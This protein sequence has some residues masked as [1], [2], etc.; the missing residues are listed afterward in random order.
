MV[1]NN[2][3]L[4]KVEST[5]FMQFKQSRAVPKVTSAIRYSRVNIRI[6][7]EFRQKPLKALR[8][9]KYPIA[10]HDVK[11]SP[12]TDPSEATFRHY[13]RLA[14]CFTIFPYLVK[15]LVG[16]NQHNRLDRHLACKLILAI[17]TGKVG[18]LLAPPLFKTFLRLC[19]SITLGLTYQ[20]SHNSRYV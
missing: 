14:K 12:K 15:T 19:G 2:F 6:T 10:R 18:R 4:W 3:K 11:I 17:R 20:L 9:I 8:V 7:Y 16:S 5:Q 13:A 1:S